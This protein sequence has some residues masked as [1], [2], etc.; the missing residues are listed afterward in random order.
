MP[1]FTELPSA[2][3]RWLALLPAAA[4]IPVC[5]EPAAA[6]GTW[7][8]FAVVLEQ[9]GLEDPDFPVYFSPANGGSSWRISWGEERIGPVA[10]W[11]DE[12]PVRAE[13]NWDVEVCGS[14]DLALEGTANG[15]FGSRHVFSAQTELLL[16]GDEMVGTWEWFETWTTADAAHTG[17]FEA[18]GRLEG[19]R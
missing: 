2:I 8:M 9:Q 19:A 1:T 12:D 6:D 10:L 5:P 3:L 7:S 14:F 16:V 18:V 17:V 13:G 15:E 11:I 4:C